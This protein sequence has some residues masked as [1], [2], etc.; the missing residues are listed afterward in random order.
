MMERLLVKMAAE[1]SVI[2]IILT[3]RAQVNN[4]FII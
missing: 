4:V 2:V 3:I 1:V